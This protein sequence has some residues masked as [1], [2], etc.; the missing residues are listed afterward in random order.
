M[1]EIK[2][3]SMYLEMYEP[4]ATVYDFDPAGNAADALCRQ[5]DT[6]HLREQILRCTSE[7][8]T[9]DLAPTSIT[10]PPTP[11]RV[12]EQALTDRIRKVSKGVANS[13]TQAPRRRR[14]IEA[15]ID[16]TRN[17]PELGLIRDSDEWASLARSCER[18]VAVALIS[19][20]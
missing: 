6:A 9:K 4:D 15:I 14:D 12:S 20:V 16:T 13:V 1:E 2:K 11:S 17:L 5:I 18:Y 3:P 19:D 7:E 8:A 10:V